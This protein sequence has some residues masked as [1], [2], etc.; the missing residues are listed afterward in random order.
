HCLVLGMSAEIGEFLARN[1]AKKSLN[2]RIH[3]ARRGCPTCGLLPFGRTFDDKTETWGVDPKKQAMVEDA[4]RRYLA[5]ESLPRLAKEPG[6]NPAARWQ[7]LTCRCGDEWV[8]EFESKKLNIHETVITKVPRL[9]DEETIIAVR[10]RAELNKT[11][12]YSKT[13]QPHL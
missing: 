8:Q 2:N 9:L 4:A 7:V 3:R 11:R 13:T 1:Q 10:I 12:N 6:I 5:G